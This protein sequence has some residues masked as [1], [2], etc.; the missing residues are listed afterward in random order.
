MHEILLPAAATAAKVVKVQQ[1]HAL[2][3]ERER[4][5]EEGSERERGSA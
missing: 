5:A 1:W 2:Q 4:G 3:G